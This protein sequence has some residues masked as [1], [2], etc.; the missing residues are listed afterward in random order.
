MFHIL[1]LQSAMYNT[2]KKSSQLMEGM[3]N[4]PL[5]LLYLILTFAKN[6]IALPH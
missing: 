6:S 2:A 1:I 4:C 3:Y 5:I